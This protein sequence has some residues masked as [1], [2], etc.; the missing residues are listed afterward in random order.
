[1]AIG[2]KSFSSRWVGRFEV[3]LAA[4]ACMSA[5][6]MGGCR[7]GSDLND[8]E[9]TFHIRAMNL[10]EDA[11][12]IQ[13]LL[14]DTAVASLEFSGGSSFTAGHAGNNAVS[15]KAVLPTTFDTEDDDD[16]PIAIGQA[17]LHAF[18]E[19]TPYTLIAYGT[20]A[21]PK[22]MLVEGWSQQDSVADDKVVLQFA[23]AATNAPQVDVYV[24]LPQAG[25]TVSQFVATLNMAEASPPLELSLTRDADELDQDSLLSG[26]LTIELRAVGTSDTLFKTEAVS[27]SE[28][29]RLLF[30]VANSVGPGPSAIRLVTLAGGATGEI[31]EKNDGAALRFVHLSADTP[32]LDVSIAPGFSEPFASGIGF[33]GVS[34]YIDVSDN[35]IGMIAVPQGDPGA[36]VFLEE[37]TATAG[38]TYSAYAIGPRSDV[39][40]L[41]IADDAR[42]VPT[43]NKFRF[44]HAAPSLDDTDAIDIYLRLPGE[45]VDF[46]DDDTV[47][48]FAA[49]PYRGLTAYLTYKEG[50]YDVYFAYAGTSTLILGPV[51]LQTR[52]GDVDTYVLMDDENGLHEL[53]PLSDVHSASDA[54]TLGHWA[55]GR[56]DLVNF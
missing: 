15:F 19:D 38:A 41:V 31:L 39:D 52:N 3:G 55:S 1:M 43:Q 50:S 44:L 22:M 37:F 18:I 20:L 34:D 26:R 23:H 12:T 13:V 17:E 35:E 21:E 27:V 36:F 56:Q 2:W 8:D 53:M 29:T 45:G 48:T 9:A 32:A 33:R 14:G 30:T 5:V 40:A 16:D 42:S 28:Q 6:L 47:P 10:I 25:V 46:E 7:L 4:L 54:A 49:V 51:P 11:A 24:T